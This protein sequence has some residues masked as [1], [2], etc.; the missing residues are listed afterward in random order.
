EAEGPTSKAPRGH[1]TSL[2]LTYGACCAA[3]RARRF[4][5]RRRRA[6]GRGGGSCERVSVRAHRGGDPPGRP[7]S[8][9]GITSTD[10][11]RPGGSPLRPTEHGEVRPEL[12]QG[13]HALRGER[14]APDV[15]TLERRERR[16]RL[17]G[18]VP[19]RRP[20]QVEDA[21]ARQ[22]R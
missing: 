20:E 1:G 11:G 13:S 6:P 3:K 2:T 12:A 14:A 22:T 8:A 7:Q 10:C 19:H 21:Q 5:R 17:D 4:S 16:Q 9:C 18:A 15:H